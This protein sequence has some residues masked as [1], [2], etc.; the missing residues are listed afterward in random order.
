MTNALVVCGH[1]PAP[2]VPLKSM[3]CHDVALEKETLSAL[4]PSG[5]ATFVTTAAGTPESLLFHQLGGSLS[6]SSKV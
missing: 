3:V 1:D 6:K 5:P 2:M 4:L